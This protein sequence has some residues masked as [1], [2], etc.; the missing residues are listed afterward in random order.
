M[1]NGKKGTVAHII[2]YAY[3]DG[4]SSEN[5]EQLIWESVEK[6]PSFLQNLSEY[7]VF[8]VN[9]HGHLGRLLRMEKLHRGIL[10]AVAGEL[11]KCVPATEVEVLQ[12][13]NSPPEYTDIGG[14]TYIVESHIYFLI[15]DNHVAYIP[16]PVAGGMRFLEKYITALLKGQ[17][18]IKQYHKI[19]LL[20]DIQTE[21]G[22]SLSSVASVGINLYDKKK[23][24]DHPL[25]THEDDSWR[26]KASL[27]FL[28]SVGIDKQEISKFKHRSIFNKIFL[29]L[30]FIESVPRAD[31][32]RLLRHF[33]EED[34][35]LKGPEGKEERGL[36]Q[37]SMRRDFEKNLSTTTIS[38]LRQDS[39]EEGIITTLKIWV[40]EGKVMI[41][42]ERFVP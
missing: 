21:D 15:V 34:L 38:P 2:K 30:G 42:P 5:L 35:V 40:A 22:V 27:S 19:E 41:P 37:L 11:I 18:V 13:R 9:D 6:K 29:S 39:V 4:F 25:L 1:A 16:I 14:A 28:E 3:F 33:P 12:D 8:E 36:L 24:S 20:P 23:S 17:R 10:G 31:V 7:S 26:E 32:N